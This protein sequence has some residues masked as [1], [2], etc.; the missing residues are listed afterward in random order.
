MGSAWKNHPSF[1][2]LFPQ[3][4]GIL[5]LWEIEKTGLKEDT[6]VWRHLHNE[7]LSSGVTLFWKEGWK[8]EEKDLLAAATS[9]QRAGSTSAERETSWDPAGKTVFPSFY[10]SC[11]LS[12]VGSVTDHSGQATES[13][14]EHQSNTF[15]SDIPEDAGSREARI[16]DETREGIIARK[17]N[18]FLEKKK[19]HTL[20]TVLL[21]Y[22]SSIA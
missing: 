3:R 21:D 9:V 17:V 20:N 15:H 8:Q 18:A 7:R 13:A 2:L 10:G 16:H 11:C 5:T 4:E 12:T 19:S 14:T 22:S 6:A 1:G